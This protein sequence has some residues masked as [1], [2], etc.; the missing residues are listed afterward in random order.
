MVSAV[1]DAPQINSELS[2]PTGPMIEPVVD[3]HSSSSSPAKISA[4]NTNPIEI[5]KDHVNDE[6]QPTQPVVIVK[7]PKKRVRNMSRVV[8]DKCQAEVS[9]KNL[10][11]HQSSGRCRTRS[12][13]MQMARRA[14][15]MERSVYNQE[16]SALT[17]KIDLVEIEED[18]DVDEQKDVSGMDAETTAALEAI[19]A[20]Q[21][22]PRPKRAKLDLPQVLENEVFKQLYQW[23]SNVASMAKSTSGDAI[24][25]LR[26][27]M[28]FKY[29][30]DR[31]ITLQELYYGLV[32]TENFLRFMTLLETSGMK[33]ASRKRYTDSVRQGLLWLDTQ[34]RTPEN[35]V[36]T[37]EAIQAMRATVAVNKKGLARKART[38]K[39]HL[40][41]EALVATGQMLS[42]QELPQLLQQ[43]AREFVDMVKRCNAGKL[44]TPVDA[45]RAQKLLVTVMAVGT[46]VAVRGGDFGQLTVEHV[47]EAQLHGVMTVPNHKTSAT[48][49]PLVIPVPQWLQWMLIRW[50][51]LFRVQLVN[52][53]D[54]KGA[55]NKLFLS[56]RGRPIVN[57]A[58]VVLTPYIKERTG[59]HVTFTTIRKFF[60][61]VSF[62]S[63]DTATQKLIS[64]GQC[65]SD[66]T[67]TAYY[68]LRQQQK[69]AHASHQAFDQRMGLSQAVNTTVP[70]KDDDQLSCGSLESLEMEVAQDLSDTEEGKEE[71]ARSSSSSSAESATSSTTEVVDWDALPD[72]PEM[73]ELPTFTVR[74]TP[75]SP[76]TTATTAADEK[77]QIMTPQQLQA[78]LAPQWTEE[79]TSALVRAIAE[80]EK[81]SQ[82]RGIVQWR[83]IRALA[84]P[85]LQRRLP[86]NLKDKMRTLPAYWLI[87][88]EQQRDLLQVPVE[89]RRVY[90][91]TAVKGR[92]GVHTLFAPEAKRARISEQSS[93]LFNPVAT[94][95]QQ[96]HVL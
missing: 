71:C 38:Q 84:H 57:F 42:E 23:L 59:K 58:Q 5:L 54:K 1:R 66:A 31:S 60:E 12:L 86:M 49:G 53:S 2:P 47:K 55:T 22:E 72:P 6:N 11:T 96:L 61:T 18:T 30:A 28:G 39:H 94:A 20:Q 95:I 4:Q 27:L 19:T 15:L 76:P 93:P 32:D 70:F 77:K 63:F 88:L 73:P 33:A 24:A 10:R 67:A 80:W 43:T 34:P 79:E 74:V 44:A 87:K 45:I 8:C 89:L 17:G 48:N 92:K 91:R 64:Q 50:A 40:S 56:P 51:N 68:Q 26:K 65:H 7:K 16:E 75:P 14:V 85:H 78:H 62:N 35:N 25:S 3:T 36:P 69:A 81:S 52:Q 21:F 82:G 9:K 46:G 41:Y 37:V 90:R 13:E 83:E 29:G